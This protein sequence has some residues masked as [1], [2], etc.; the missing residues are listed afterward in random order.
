MSE[1]ERMARIK[2]LWAELNILI[3]EDI[4]ERINSYEQEKVKV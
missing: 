2:E 3:N 4:N 1:D